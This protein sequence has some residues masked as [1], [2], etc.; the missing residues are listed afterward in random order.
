MATI[1]GA[2]AGLEL[3]TIKQRMMDGREESRKLGYCAAGGRTLPTGVTWD[4]K[5]KTYDY[6]PV[7]APKI[8]EAFHMVASGE[9]N[10]GYIIRTLHLCLRPARGAPK[11][12]SPTSLRRLLENRLFIGE[13]V[14]DKRFDLSTPKE[15]LM[16]LGKD[17]KWHKRNR[18]LIAREP[19]EVYVREVIT[20]GLVSRE[21]F[22]KV[23]NILRA[24]SD[25]VH[26][27]H[28]LHADRRPKFTYRGLLFCG[29]CGQPI[30]TVTQGDGYYRCR[31][32]FRQRGGKNECKATSMGRQKLE[33]ELARLFSQEFPRKHFLAELL[34]KHYGSEGRKDTARQRERLIGQR[35][36]LARRRERIIEFALDGTLT[37]GDRDR[38]LKLV[39][40]DLD[41]NR[42]ALDDLADTPLP[43]LAEW[44]D[45][46]RPFNVFET[47]SMEEK[48]R[49][50]TSRFQEIRVKDYR[51]VSL[52][53][54]TGEVTTP[55]V[56][57]GPEIDPTVC[58]SCGHTISPS[59]G[60]TLGGVTYCGPCSDGI[61][62]EDE[63]IALAQR[64]VPGP[65]L[66]E[67]CDDSYQ[68]L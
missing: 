24:K 26:Q 18:P 8:A 25:K 59:L 63:Q 56:V 5:S 35:Q 9:T 31:D 68:R 12:A 58:Y 50:L 7:Y 67:V 37:K 36:T 32:H 28:M 66:A 20:P 4:V 54:L 52:Y 15:Q 60:V 22:E 21:I 49:L 6:D 3:S 53:L 2:V 62:D 27:S 11:L 45:F 29:S 23:Q 46:L 47:L 41:A 16:Y 42:R 61:A 30:Y 14:W 33:T 64:G 55:K 39:D 10:F 65:L 13:R 44:R 57:P 48:R 17:N 51:V 19:H 40:D 34:E 43:S 38:R 1:Q